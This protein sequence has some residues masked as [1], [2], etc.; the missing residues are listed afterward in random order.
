MKNTPAPT[1]RH[2]SAFPIDAASAHP[3]PM[4]R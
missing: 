2:A 1:S 3:V 4:P